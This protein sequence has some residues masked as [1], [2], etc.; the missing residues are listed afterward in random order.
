MAPFRRSVQWCALATV[1]TVGCPNETDHATVDFRLQLVGNDCDPK[2]PSDNFELVWR[3][4]DSDRWILTRDD[5]MVSPAPVSNASRCDAETRAP[6]IVVGRR[7]GNHLNLGQHL[8][9]ANP[10][11]RISH[12]LSLG[13]Y[14]RR[15]LS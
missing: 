9:L 10:V 3:I 13:G 8:E 14:L 11:E 4:A 7:G 2:I 6:A 15:S 5:R 12:D 1:A